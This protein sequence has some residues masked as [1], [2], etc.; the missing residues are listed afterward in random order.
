[1]IKTSGTSRAFPTGARRDGSAGKGRFDLLPLSALTRVA[2][3][4][5]KGAAVYGEN[6]WKLGMPIK[7]VLLDSA[8]RHLYK[9]VDGQ[10]DEDH[11]AAA[12]WN[13]LCAIEIQEKVA[14]KELPKEL[15][16]LPKAPTEAV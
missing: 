6:N 1:M 4:F 11:L 3:H 7:S 15:N 5:E 13:V 9:A 2:Q 12:A 14:R 8:I 10:E 16:D